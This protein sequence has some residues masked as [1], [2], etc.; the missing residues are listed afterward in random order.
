[1][2]TKRTYAAVFLAGLLSTLFIAGSDRV[3]YAV[4]TGIGFMSMGPIEFLTRRLR[5]VVK[6]SL[7]HQQLLARFRAAVA[8][9]LAFQVFF[10]LIEI[11][12]NDLIMIP[13]NMIVTT[14]AFMNWVKYD[15]DFWSGLKTR[16]AG[17]NRSRAYPAIC[18][19]P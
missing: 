19:P 2:P 17:L 13:H 3:L 6:G 1:M 9:A 18:A 8:Q 11:A 4:L 7:G 10:V 15:K 12:L 5:I 16:A 14:W